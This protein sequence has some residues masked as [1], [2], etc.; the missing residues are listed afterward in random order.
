MRIPE[1]KSNLPSYL[2]KREVTRFEK[3]LGGR[4]AKGQKNRQQKKRGC[5]AKGKAILYPL[6]MAWKK[7]NL[8]T[9]RKGRGGFREEN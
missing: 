9:C 4:R 3:R 6:L 8:S 1:R 2:N 5:R 7:E